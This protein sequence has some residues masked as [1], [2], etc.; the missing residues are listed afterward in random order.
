MSSYTGRR[1]VNPLNKNI[2][3]RTGKDVRAGK[4]IRIGE[5][6]FENFDDYFS[7]SDAEVSRNYS[8]RQTIR[9]ES[10]STGTQ[11]SEDEIKENQSSHCNRVSQS[12]P[13]AALSN[14]TCN[15]ILSSQTLSQGDAPNRSKFGWLRNK[16]IGRRTGKNI[17]ANKQIRVDEYGFENFDDYF[18]E[19]DVSSLSSRLSVSVVK[20]Q[21]G[22]S[23]INKHLIEHGP[24]S[25][26]SQDSH[27][28]GTA[29]EVESSESSQEDRMNTQQELREQRSSITNNSISSPRNNSYTSD[30]EGTFTKETGKNSIHTDS[31]RSLS[32]ND[33]QTV[34]SE[35]AREETLMKKQVENSGKQGNNTSQMAQSQSRKSSYIDTPLSSKRS[36]SH[37]SVVNDQY[38]NSKISHQY[39]Q[40]IKNDKSILL[41]KSETDSREQKNSS[42]KH[43]TSIGVNESIQTNQRTSEKSRAFSSTLQHADTMN[44]TEN[45]DGRVSEHNSDD[46]HVPEGNELDDSDLS[47]EDTETE[48]DNDQHSDE[49]MAEESESERAADTESADEVV[50]EEKRI[51]TEVTKSRTKPSHD[52]ILKEKTV[53]NSCTEIEKINKSG[54]RNLT[55]AQ[56][57]TNG[58]ISV[59]ENESDIYEDGDDL[60]PSQ[61]QTNIDVAGNR[62]G[63]IT[64][65]DIPASVVSFDRTRK[66]L[67][68]SAVEASE[69]SKQ[70]NKSRVEKAN[71]ELLNTK[72]SLASKKVKGQFQPLP[73]QDNTE[74]D[75]TDV[76]KKLTDTAIVTGDVSDFL[77]LASRSA[78]PWGPQVADNDD[79]NDDDDDIMILDYGKQKGTSQIGRKK[80][81]KDKTRNQTQK[82]DTESQSDSG[83]QT[84]MNNLKK[85]SKSEVKV[86]KTKRSNKNRRKTTHELKEVNG[87]GVSLK[88]KKQNKKPLNDDL[89]EHSNVNTSAEISHLGED[90]NAYDDGDDVNESVQTLNAEDKTVETNVK[91]GKRKGFNKSDKSSVVEKNTAVKRNGKNQVRKSTKNASNKTENIDRETKESNTVTSCVNTDETDS[92]K[93][94]VGGKHKPK[95]NSRKTNKKRNSSENNTDNVEFKEEIESRMSKLKMSTLKRRARENPDDIGLNDDDNN[96]NHETDD[97]DENSPVH[98]RKKSTK[99]LKRI[100]LTDGENLREKNGQTFKRKSSSEEEL[101]TESKA[102]KAKNSKSNR[103]SKGKGK[104]SKEKI[105]ASSSDNGDGIQ[106]EDDNISSE[107]PLDESGK[108][109]PKAESRLSVPVQFG[110]GVSF[111]VSRRSEVLEDIGSGY[112]GE[113]SVQMEPA[114]GLTPCISRPGAARKSKGRRVTICPEENIEHN[115]SVGTPDDGNSPSRINKFRHS[116]GASVNA[117]PLPDPNS[118][119]VHIC[120]TT[121]TATPHPGQCE[122]SVIEDRLIK[123]SPPEEGLRR[124]QR[125]RLK[126]IA[127]YKNEQVVFD[128]RRRSGPAIIGV[129][130]SLEVKWNKMEEEKRKKRMLKYQI[131]KASQAGRDKPYRKLSIHTELPKGI[132]LEENSDPEITIYNQNTQAEDGID[133]IGKRDAFKPVGPKHETPKK[134]DPY[135]ITQQL[136]HPC[137]S[138]GTLCIKPNA[139]KPEQLVTADYIVFFI[140]HGKVLVKIHNTTVLVETGDTFLVP[141]GNTYSISNLRS[142]TARLF[143]TIHKQVD[144]PDKSSQNLHE[145]L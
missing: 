103:K 137:M 79:D 26:S 40:E 4:H 69:E 123:P 6:G 33:D 98:E 53:T 116:F 48:E 34:E 45:E 1:F 31:N 107:L 87:S 81:S 122:E 89:E 49:S 14:V 93:E 50:K 71:A 18:S 5:D 44:E 112:V 78:L 7:E 139:E 64:K 140:E 46:D 97:T 62:S 10:E 113:P 106:D 65:L 85:G 67:S 8:R 84:E 90:I 11:D 96:N 63:S 120:E 60:R 114:G 23:F 110:S 118:T 13:S 70:R 66:R 35:L 74:K 29:D 144:I 32:D 92:D 77:C 115:V 76:N 9:E 3:R 129:K 24:A 111:R 59:S 145:G 27:R 119:P 131:R 99:K 38:S 133:C 105:S 138:A 43:K 51:E 39:T 36:R 47:H 57:N 109:T 28:N 80:S 15:K 100:S 55:D 17:T 117:T 21:P 41:R 102:K 134:E 91:K 94:K 82:S 37:I 61:A 75:N 136:S 141:V 142:D 12:M 128:Y 22:R 52:E 108:R 16:N 58:D 56:V 104:T 72:V 132:D 86:Q 19:T 42:G 73:S 95:K 127:W 30:E 121:H 130:P 25:V 54:S 125:T 83:K 20:P 126:P 143:Y 135:L 68:Y 88:K 2:G 101:E 124:S